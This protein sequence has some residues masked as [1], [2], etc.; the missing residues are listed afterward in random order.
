MKRIMIIT[1]LLMVTSTLIFAGGGRDRGAPG[2]TNLMFWDMGWGAADRGETAVRNLIDRFTRIHPHITVENQFIPWAGYFDIF[3]TAIQSGTAPDVSTGGGAQVGLYATM[4]ALINLQPIVDEW[5]A[6]N[7]PI[8]NDFIPITTE[9]FRFGG[10]LSAFVFGVDPK[11]I[12]YRKDLLE[13]A[14]VTRL[15]TTFDEFAQTLRMV[16]ARFPNQV[17]L[18][19]AAADAGITHNA[20]IFLFANGAGWIT[21][22]MRPN[23][24]SR[25]AQ[26]SLNFVRMLV[27]EGLIS[28]GAAGHT[29]SDIERIFMTEG[30][31]FIMSSSLGAVRQ[32]PFFDQIA[33]LPPIAG[34]SASR[35]FYPVP[36]NPI[37]AF[38]N[39]N[40][41]SDA[42]RAFIKFFMENSRDYFIEWS[43]SNF[44]PRMSYYEHPFWADS[45]ANMQLLEHAIFEGLPHWWPYAE[46]FPAFLQ[47]SGERLFGRALQQVIMGIDPMRA[48]AEAD[49]AIQNALDTYN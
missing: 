12:M 29:G 25:E 11:F 1:V 38:S 22:D 3:M 21:R 37:M 39:R 6:E 35:G 7:N 9:L 33:I 41:Q 49:T 46:P 26:E 31:A 43:H 36:Q 13:Q 47:I 27:N 44:P 18:L 48:G 23:M 28:P 10:E 2:Q 17:P 24:Q 14:G 8:L 45:P 32:A 40:N 5:R 16:R 15:P 42:A 19:L 30:A 34:P 20:S 4:G